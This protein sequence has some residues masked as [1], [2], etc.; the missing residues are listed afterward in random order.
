MYQ[1]FYFWVQQQKKRLHENY[2]KTRDVYRFGIFGRYLVGISWYLPNLYRR[3]TWSVHFGII[4]FGE[5]PCF[6]WKGRHSP[7]FEGPSPH[8]VEKRVSCQTL[9]S[10]RQILKCS[11]YQPKY[12]P[13]STSIWYINTNTGQ[14]ARI[15]TVYNSNKHIYHYHT[16][17]FLSEHF[18]RKIPAKDYRD[19]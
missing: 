1:G 2:I 19:I 6:T 16:V 7:L 10:S 5:N 3:K 18:A 15:K 14:A 12:R 13:T 9:K 11:K 4:F 17:A 8:F